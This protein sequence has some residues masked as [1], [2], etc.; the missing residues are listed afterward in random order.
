VKILIFTDLDGTLLNHSDYAYEDAKPALKRIKTLNIPLIIVTSKTKREV[1]I[2][3]EE[4]DSREPF[5][6]ENGGGIFFPSGY[7]GLEMGD[8]IEKE[9][10]CV[11]GLGKPYTEIR[12]FFKRARKE[13]GITGFGD[14][15]VEDIAKLTALPTEKA[16]FAKQ[17]DFTEPFLLERGDRR[18]GELEALAATEGMKITRG[19]RFYHLIGVDQDKGKAV[20][21]AT[22][23]F[24]KNW[25][26]NIAAIGLG[27]SQNDIP[28]LEHVDIPCLIPKTNGQYEEVSLANLQR[29]RYPGSKG[30]NEIVNVLLDRLTEPGA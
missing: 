17:R 11:I 16:R 26:E 21:I 25:N 10:Y 14:M 12:R 2:L 29:A 18:I 15:T 5:I 22:D 24:R 7:G 1:E 23:I 20:Q 19:G 30:W 3:Q 8:C 13:F 27:D 9:G 28:L 4:L 6:V